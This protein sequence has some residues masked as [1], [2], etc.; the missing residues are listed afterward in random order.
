MI[1]IPAIDL[2]E[3]KCV[4]LRQG[5]MEDVT[6]YSDH[7]GQM[8]K[9]WESLGAELLHVVDLDGAFAGEPKNLKSIKEIVNSINIPVEVGGGIRT[10]E[11]IE[12]LINAGVARVILGTKA[13]EDPDFV[14]KAADRHIGKIVV[15][16]DA[17]DGMAAASG[18]ADVTSMSALE[19]AEKMSKY[20]I[21]DIIYTDIKRDGMLSG[22]NLEATKTMVMFSSVPIIASGGISNLKDVKDL[23]K[24]KGLK[25][26][27]TGK[28]LYDGTLSLREAIRLCTTMS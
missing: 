23:C 26:F 7:P 28:A 3:G 13:I 27:I 14:K 6:I 22:P 10:M 11:T 16:I 18:W 4:R 15:G 25:G 12:K 1:P 17:K 2:K 9:K 19:L 8:A 21:A 20:D 5:R 24:I